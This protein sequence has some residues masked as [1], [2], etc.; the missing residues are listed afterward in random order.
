MLRGARPVN[1]KRGEEEGNKSKCRKKQSWRQKR[2]DEE[3]EES[4]ETTMRILTKHT[5]I[6]I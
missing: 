4:E 6:N 1:W 2:E 3:H 5:L